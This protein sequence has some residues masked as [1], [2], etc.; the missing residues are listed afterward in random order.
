MNSNEIQEYGAREESHYI[1]PDIFQLCIVHVQDYLKL[2]YVHIFYIYVCKY[3]L[4]K[5]DEYLGISRV[6]VACHISTVFEAMQVA[7]GWAC[8]RQTKVRQALL[9]SIVS[10]SYHFLLVHLFKLTEN[11]ISWPV[12]QTLFYV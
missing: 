3:N 5:S 11:I 9:N 6:Y 1:W 2:N 4:E 7:R 8:R 12:R 10:I